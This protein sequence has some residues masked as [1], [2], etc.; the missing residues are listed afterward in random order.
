MY[1][2]Y[3]FIYNLYVDDGIRIYNSMYSI[4]V[5]DIERVERNRLRHFFKYW[6]EGPSN[7]ANRKLISMQTK[8]GEL[9]QLLAK[10]FYGCKSLRGETVEVVKR[11]SFK[12]I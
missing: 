11:D 8:G 9:V 2:E 4:S 12:I 5:Y 10:R 1:S 7:G 3:I 6:N